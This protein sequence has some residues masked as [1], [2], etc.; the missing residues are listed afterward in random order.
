MAN[1][2]EFGRVVID[3]ESAK[4]EANL[5][6]LQTQM[7]A[8]KKAI[9]EA[10]TP[11]KKSEL[12]KQLKQASDQAAKLKKQLAGKIQ[13]IIDG[14]L[15]G[16]SIRDLEAAARTLK[17]QLKNMNPDSAEFVKGAQ[18]I[19]QIDGRIRD[20]NGTLRGSSG[21]WGRMGD[22]VKA[23][24]VIA[25]SYLGFQSIVRGIDQVISANSRLSDS[26]ADIRKTTGLS[27]QAANE[28][29]EQLQKIDTRTSTEELRNMAVVAGQLG[30]ANEKVAAAETLRRAGDV[31][32]FNKGIAAAQ[33]ELRG[34]IEAVDRSNVALGDE[35]SGGAEEITTVLGKLRNILG[36]I[37]S[38]QVDQDLLHIGNAL[39]VLGASGQA[40]APVV[41]EF[42]NRIGAVAIPLG[43][44]SGEV[45]GLS[46]T[47]QE[48]GVKTE[49]GGSAISR[50][51]QKMTVDT[52]DFAG[53][54]GMDVKEFEKLVNEDLF[55]AF[56]KVV[57][58]TQM[59]GDSATKFSAILDDLGVDG[60]RTAQVMA[61]LRNNTELLTEKVQLAGSAV[62]ET[63]SIQA[64]FDIKNENLAAR[65]DKLKKRFIDFFTAPE[66]K[67]FLKDQVIRITDFLNWLGRVP[68]II[69]ENRGAIAALTVATIAYNA[70][71]IQAAA[72][73]VTK[74]AALQAEAIASKASA[75]AIAI[76]NAAE[77]GWIITK[78][79][80]TGKVK[81]ATV[82]QRIFN[83]V[84]MAN[85]YA[86]VLGAL[87]AIVEGIDLYRKNTKEAIQLEKDKKILGD[88]IVKV[89]KDLE[90]SMADFNS[91]IERFNQL[92]PV[93][94]KEL[95]DKIRL[96]LEEA[97]ATLIQLQAEKAR[98]EEASSSVGT[99]EFLWNTLKA[100]GNTTE[101]ALN[102]AMDAAE[103]GREAGEQY[104]EGIEQI[105]AKIQGLEGQL[106]SAEKV[107]KA[108]DLAMGIQAKTLDQYNEKMN[109][110]Q[111]ALKGAVIGSENYKNIQLE[112]AK[113]QAE[114]AKKTAVGGVDTDK[115]EEALQKLRDTLMDIEADLEADKQAAYQREITNIQRKYDQLREEAAG[116]SAELKKISELEK[117]ELIALEEQF[118]QKVMDLRDKRSFDQLSKDEQEVQAVRDKYQKL[119]DEFEGFSEKILEIEK[120]RD[121]EI[122]QIRNEQNEKRLSS[123]YD[124]ADKI[125]E[126]SL[127][128]TERAISQEANKWEQLI[129]QAEEHNAAAIER[130]EQ[131]IFDIS[132]LIEM[133]NAAIL[134]LTKKGNEKELKEEEKIQAIKK[135]MVNDSFSILQ[136]G[137]ALAAQSGE[138]YASFQQGLTLAQIAMDTAS[139]IASLT[140]SS[141]ANPANAV[142]FGGA[143]VAQFVAGLARILAN[144]AAAKNILGGASVPQYERGGK[145]PKESKVMEGPSH[146]EG[147]L[148]ITD[149]RS[150]RVV[151]EAEGGEPIISI[152]DY[153]QNKELID[154]IMEGNGLSDRQRPV[155]SGNFEMD[156][157]FN[158]LKM[159]DGGFIPRYLSD[160]QPQ[161]NSK[162]LT[163]TIR[164]ERSSTGRLVDPEKISGGSADPDQAGIADLVVQLAPILSKLNDQ[165]ENP[166]PQKN[167]ILYQDI[168][169][170][171]RKIGVIRDK[172]GLKSG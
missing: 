21:L 91:E 106:T 132:E 135:Q 1:N 77:K 10:T 141:E 78:A 18:A 146:K 64:E 68:K 118:D 61:A 66:I 83:R 27:E 158:F 71:T 43:L 157:R 128:D 125:F 90:S 35:F 151:A 59:G 147:G 11:D 20:L 65:I 97:R 171:Q 60:V 6:K 131:E 166:K 98:V 48:L 15:A 2:T 109:L 129:I 89:N 30:I 142:T 103:A 39:N 165:L 159:E 170:A 58:G 107:E 33:E 5:K 50:I 80:F 75:A 93:E 121:E 67:D 110:L 119:I 130:G 139:A 24:G 3:L 70:R 160:P 111:L 72:A 53:V 155:V 8:L 62:K 134:K 164:I 104:A 13:V 112:I 16:K 12:N 86:A 168:E 115:A 40:T 122:T 7:K 85:P 4:A 136:S 55:G 73:A 117:Q 47:L 44:T 17:R 63:S 101:A 100:G 14:D 28:L 81:A 149:N 152:R 123:T 96:K 41:A 45:L 150:G 94:R 163:E 19:R 120:L 137:M 95:T 143:G 29:N 84:L 99:W 144:M 116:N 153:Q 42:A 87:I 108:F 172:A 36:D 49:A 105:T 51:L 74:T 82:A 69:E 46:A 133:K 126:L 37:K 114:M 56:M 140:K 127:T 138:D 79:V 169:E 145:L 88:Q 32:G 52:K 113:L 31:E 161:I 26:L 148:T 9:R 102:N 167:F 124:L 25:G 156:N 38:D 162:R 54:A 22:Q 154:S 57:E 76:G 23:F 92:S 34:F